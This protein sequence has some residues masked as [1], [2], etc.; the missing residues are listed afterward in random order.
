MLVISDAETEHA[1]VSNN[2]A[3]PEAD[4]MHPPKIIRMRGPSTSDRP[5]RKGKTVEKNPYARYIVL[6][7]SDIHVPWAPAINSPDQRPDR[8]SDRYIPVR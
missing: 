1:E 4:A 3:V 5:N 6:R 2:N 8:M 7:I